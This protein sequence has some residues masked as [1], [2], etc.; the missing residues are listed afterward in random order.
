MTIIPF[1]TRFTADQAKARL[2]AAGL[3][4]GDVLTD[5]TFAMIVPKVI[6]SIPKENTFVE[7]GSTVDLV[8]GYQ[9]VR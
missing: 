7:D 3:V 1:V 9:Y 4:P 5:T 2:V 8:I 6:R